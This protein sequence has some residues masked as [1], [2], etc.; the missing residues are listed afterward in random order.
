MTYV[1]MNYSPKKGINVIGNAFKHGSIPRRRRS[2]RF[3]VVLVVVGSILLLMGVFPIFAGMA[4]FFINSAMTASNMLSAFD[5][6]T[7]SRAMV[8]KEIQREP[9]R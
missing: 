5:I 4:L 3:R 7:D 1:A 6:R 8:F 2:F 9:R